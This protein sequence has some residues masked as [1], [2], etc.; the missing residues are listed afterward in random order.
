MCLTENCLLPCASWKDSKKVYLVGN[1]WNCVFCDIFC[2]RFG[3]HVFLQSSVGLTED[4]LLPCASWKDSKKIHL[5]GDKWNCVF[6]DILC[7]WFVNHG[8]L[9]SSVWLSEFSRICTSELH[10]Q[11]PVCICNHID[12]KSR[13]IYRVCTKIFYF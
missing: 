2:N 12:A 5:V 10:G 8:L 3:N 13:E 11:S 9:L 6:C 7:N 1:K 4:C